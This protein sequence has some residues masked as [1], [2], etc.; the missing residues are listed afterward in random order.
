MKRRNFISGAAAGTLG[1]KILSS[2]GIFARDI[3]GDSGPIAKRPY[4]NTGEM[5]SIIGFGGIVVMNAE[6]SHANEVVGESYE[7][8]INYYDVA[9]TYGNAQ[10]KLGPA[11][12]P[13]RKEC[14]LACKSTQ[15]KG[16]K[17]LEEF[18]NSLKVLRTDYFD[19]YQLHAIQTKEDIEVAFGPGGAVEAID[20]LKREGKVKYLG[21]SAH[22]IEAAM[23]ALKYYDFNS[24][25]FPVNFAT[26]YAGNFGEQV[27]NYAKSKG[28]AI[29]AL[30]AMAKTTWKEGET[31]TYDKT[32]YRP[33]D[34]AEEAYMGL[35]FTLS[36]PVTAAVPPGE[37]KLY[38]LALD[39]APKFIPLT[40]DEKYDLHQ[41]AKTLEP[42]FRYPSDQ[43]DLKGKA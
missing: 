15:R 29:L 38:R 21:F 7:R 8:G 40:D 17:L 1:A 10:E 41:N 30:K 5:L 2:S 23:A 14:F 43:F 36:Q 9:P 28:A 18:Y 35:R 26:W 27:I 24:V 32:W 42:I 25:L 12:E 34:D 19:L 6:Q 4:G 33:L 39:L 16:D 22:S 31:R 37:E 13:F 20:K 3:K 11:L